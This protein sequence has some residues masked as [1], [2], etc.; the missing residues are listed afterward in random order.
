MAV[1]RLIFVQM[2]LSALCPERETRPR[3]ALL[4]HIRRLAPVSSG[5]GRTLR[6]RTRVICFLLRVFIQGPGVQTRPGRRGDMEGNSGLA[7][8]SSASVSFPRCCPPPRLL[9]RGLSCQLSSF[10]CH[11]TGEYRPDLP[12]SLLVDFMGSCGLPAAFQVL[13]THLPPLQTL[14]SRKPTCTPPYAGTCHPVT[15]VE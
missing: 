8:T 9:L 15:L 11:P 12:A 14:R 1:L 7:P 2:T 5:H 10:P 6:M 3:S 4:W 13:A